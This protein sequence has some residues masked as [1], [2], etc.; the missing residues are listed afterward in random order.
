VLLICDGGKVGQG[1][2]FNVVIMEEQTS[3]LH[4]KKTKCI[5]VIFE[6]YGMCNCY[7]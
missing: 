2:K 3:L 4:W 7:K 1:K 5:V 6:K